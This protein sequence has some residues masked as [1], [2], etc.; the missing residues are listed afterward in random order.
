MISKALALARPADR[1]DSRPDTAIGAGT[2]SDRHDRR[3]I[4]LLGL[5]EHATASA[6]GPLRNVAETHVYAKWLLERP[7]ENVRLGRAYRLTMNAIDQ[8]REQKRMLEKVARP[9][10]LTLQVAPMLGTAA[11][12]MS[13][14]LTELAAVLACRWRFGWSYRGCAEPDDRRACRRSVADERA[15]D[16][17][18]LARWLAPATGG[19]T[20][21]WSLASATRGW[22]LAGTSAAMTPTAGADASL[23]G[24]PG[25]AQFPGV[26]AGCGSRRGGG[27]RLGLGRHDSGLLVAFGLREGVWQRVR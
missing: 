18:H 10:A 21:C 22:A 24:S 7:D 20:G 2:G 1:V 19:W 17:D 25:A 15:L 23:H 13:S 12:R 27:E 5:R 6:L 4:A 16:A 3:A 9:S 26:R 8:L 11:E 14:R